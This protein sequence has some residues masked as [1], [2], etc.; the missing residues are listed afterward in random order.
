MH[1]CAFLPFRCVLGTF[2]VRGAFFFLR[3][4]GAFLLRFGACWLRSDAFSMGFRNAPIFGSILMARHASNRYGKK[5]LP[6]GN[7]TGMFNFLNNAFRSTTLFFSKTY[8][9]PMTAESFSLD[10]KC[11]FLKYKCF[12]ET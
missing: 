9:Y 10:K 7:F 12:L 4:S 6:S 8:I 2:L 5:L 11:F 3:F 1:L